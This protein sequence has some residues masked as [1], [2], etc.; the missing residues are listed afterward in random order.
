M[1][2][3]I[4]GDEPDKTKH[5]S[6]PGS[7]SSHAKDEHP[8]PGFGSVMNQKAKNKPKPKNADAA[9]IRERLIPSCVESDA[10]SEIAPEGQ[11]YRTRRSSTSRIANA[12]ALAPAFM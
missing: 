6:A 1:R 8:P 12:M 7:A 4:P 11:A 3:C 9:A 2:P 5:A 10:A